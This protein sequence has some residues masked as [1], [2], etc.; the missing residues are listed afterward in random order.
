M[1]SRSNRRT[2]ARQMR[3]RSGAPGPAHH[4]HSIRG[5]RV[6]RGNRL[7]STE[8][9]VPRTMGRGRWVP[10]PGCSWVIH[11]VDRRL[12]AGEGVANHQRAQ[13]LGVD[14]SPFQCCVKATPTATVRRFEAQVN[15]RRNDAC[16][17]DGVAELE[18]RVSAPIE[19]AVKRVAEGTQII[20][21]CGGFHDDGFCS[22]KLPAATLTVPP[23]LKRLKHKFG[24][25]VHFVGRRAGPPRPGCGPLERS[26]RRERRVP[27]SSSGSSL[28]AARSAPDPTRLRP[29]S[30]LDPVR[31]SSGFPTRS[32]SRARTRSS[33]GRRWRSRATLD[34]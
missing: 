22:A 24:R 20:E 32:S 23:L 15:G 28:R 21:G 10:R 19:A 30:V 34:A 1:C 8:T 13:G 14:S 18:E 29:G 12:P 6:G 7:T 5:S 25:P 9:R 2:Y 27:R 3:S 31:G 17:E 4:S 16:S 11:G 26:G 33:G